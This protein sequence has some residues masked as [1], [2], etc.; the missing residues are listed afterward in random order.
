MIAEKFEAFHRDNPHVYNIFVALAH[1]WIDR[2]GRR[3]VGISALTERA[4][5]EIAIN[6]R[7]ADAEYKLSNS[8]RAFYARLIMAQ[9]P[10]L[11]GLFD[12]RPSEADEWIVGY[13]QRGMVDDGQL[14]LMPL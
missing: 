10:E 4:R 13:L 9:E 14:V 1:Q 6:T 3:K 8:Y 7:D 11:D 12:L 2:T 5:W